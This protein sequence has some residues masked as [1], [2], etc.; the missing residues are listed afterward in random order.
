MSKYDNS[1][2]R[3]RERLLSEERAMEMLR[4]CEYGFLSIAASDAPDG[5]AAGYGVPLNY[6]FDGEAVWFHCAPEGEKLRHIAENPCVS[7][8]VVG[9]TAPPTRAVHHWL[10]ERDGEGA[11]GDC[12]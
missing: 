8:C 10:R 5:R 1:A 3:R 6:V 9:R 4:E 11:C 2:V 7:F 12:G